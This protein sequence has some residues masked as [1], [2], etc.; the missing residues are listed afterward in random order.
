MAQTT[1]AA[2][3]TRRRS[4][5]AKKGLKKHC[6]STSGKFVPCS[7]AGSR[8]ANPVEN[9][10]RRRSAP[11][12][13]AAKRV[14]RRNPVAAAAVAAPQFA[15]NPTRRAVGPRYMDNPR[16]RP[17]TGPYA[18]KKVDH[19]PVVYVD[20]YGRKHHQSRAAEYPRRASGAKRSMG[21]RCRT[22]TGR[23][24]ACGAGT[25]KATTRSGGTRRRM[26]ARRPRRASSVYMTAPRAYRNNPVNLASVGG[27]AANPVGM[28]VYRDN[29]VTNL[30]D[31]AMATGGV[32]L[33]YIAAD[34]LDRF[35]A[36]M[37][38]AGGTQPYFGRDAATLINSRPNGMRLAAGALGTG[39]MAAV[40]YYTARTRP[41]VST[42][43]GG[44]A[45]GF[46]VKLLA[47]VWQ[48]YIAPAIWKVDEAKP[49]SL[50]D[51]MF[52][53]EQKAVQ[54]K[55]K[56]EYK[57]PDGGRFSATQGANA[58]I[59]LVSSGQVGGLPSHQGQGA[60]PVPFVDAAHS[61]GA[62][63]GTVAG[64]SYRGRSLRK[65]KSGS[66]GV[67]S[68]C[69]G[70]N[71]CYE[72]CHDACTSC[73]YSDESA[74]NCTVTV[75][76]GDDFAAL[77]ATVGVSMD[78][79]VALNNGVFN[80]VEGSTVTLP[81]S[82]CALLSSEDGAVQ[83]PSGSPVSV[84]APPRGGVT[85]KVPPVMPPPRQGTPS[86]PISPAAPTLTPA[87]PVKPATTII[88]A[89]LTINK[90]LTTSDFSQ[91]A[92]DAAASLLAKDSGGSTQTARDAAIS[93]LASG[94]RVAG[95]FFNDGN[96]GYNPF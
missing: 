41:N 91:T 59:S 64:G 96:E 20:S 75:Q 52:S 88:N 54:D 50:A 19:R 13:K 78:D 39:L 74:P 51:R 49:N 90:P 66:I 1:F 60:A 29:P 81:Y 25:R 35:L 34:T 71:A 62:V 87:S 45:V 76:A 84:I 28:G 82:M 37:K 80:P 73:G 11:K 89:G 92:R 2:N 43:F 21:K 42:F 6:R 95:V 79:V 61:N 68:S 14:Y 40:S 55:V 58:Q 26:A 3:P 17:G 56:A 93:I 94:S 72:G 15:P 44:L 36:T 10:R 7:T 70:V 12:R 32:A 27:F 30:K 53:L 67:C 63:G 33:G 65:R 69:R 4:A 48:W 24:A 86:S 18:G 23:F 85:V 22:S 46:G 47:S 16:G 8:R 38:P 83:T 31:F 77:A 5:G 9:P 57:S